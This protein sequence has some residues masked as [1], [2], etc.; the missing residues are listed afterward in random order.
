MWGRNKKRVEALGE[1]RIKGA[2]SRH[3]RRCLSLHFSGI[4]KTQI[5]KYAHPTMRLARHTCIATV[6]NQV[7]M[8]VRNLLGLE[9]RHQLILCLAR[10]L[11]SIRKSQ[12]RRHPEHMR[13]HSHPWFLPD[14]RSHHIRSLATHPRQSH[15]SLMIRRN[16]S[17][18][19]FDKDAGCLQQVIGLAARKGDALQIRMQTVKISLSH[20]P[21]CRIPL[22]EGRR[23]HVD[24][25]VR[26]L[27]RKDDSDKELK[28]IM[29]NQFRLGNRDHLRQALQDL[30][31]LLPLSHLQRIGFP[32][33][34]T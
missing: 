9:D 10:R 4:P 27:G 13:V 1:E 17:L 5:S 34:F 30:N 24:P 23:G 29:I 19:F 6:Q 25:L 26:A 11:G 7:V 28:R 18:M 33:R 22:K 32:C 31:R 16:L 3:C 21:R 12:P 20:I 8:G 2:E 14:H 15:Q